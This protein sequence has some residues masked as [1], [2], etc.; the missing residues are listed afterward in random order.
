MKLWLDDV[1][2]P[3]EGWVWAKTAQEAI[4]LLLTR[5]IEEIS[6]DHDLGEGDVGYG[7]QVASEIERLAWEGKI[8]PLKWRVHR[9]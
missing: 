6:L 7:Y 4:D 3:P 1:R 2:T 8:P 9:A 5:E